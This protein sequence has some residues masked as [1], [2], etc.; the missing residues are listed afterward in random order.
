M[1]RK[2]LLIGPMAC[3]KSRNA[4]R[5]AKAF[6]LEKVFEMDGTANKYALRD[7]VDALFICTKL[8][9]GIRREQFDVV[10]TVNS[11]L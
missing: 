6:R 10:I 5:I 8:P 3:G 1:S 4:E 7:D 11:G 2:V 9:R